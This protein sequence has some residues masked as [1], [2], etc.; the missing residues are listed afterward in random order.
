MPAYVK[1][2]HGK[3]VTYIAA[4]SYYSLAVTSNGSM[5]SWG[6]AKMG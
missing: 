6:E 2:F 5:Y 3:K 4:G 1:Y